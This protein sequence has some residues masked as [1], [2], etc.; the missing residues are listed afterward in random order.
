MIRLVKMQ[1]NTFVLAD[2]AGKIVYLRLLVCGL[3]RENRKHAGTHTMHYQSDPVQVLAQF[4]SSW[5]SPD[6]LAAF[7]SPALQEDHRP[8]ENHRASRQI[9]DATATPRRRKAD[10]P[11]DRN[12]THQQPSSSLQKV[13]DRLLEFQRCY[14]ARMEQF[15]Q[16][17]QADLYADV[18]GT[19]KLNR[20]SR[21]ISA[22]SPR[23]A[24]PVFDRLSAPQ[25]PSEEPSAAEEVD[26]AALRA[27]S[28]AI[29][30][31][32]ADIPHRGIQAQIDWDRSRRAKQENQR[33]EQ[34][35]RERQACS[36]APK[37]NPK[38]VR[39]V[40]HVNVADPIR[41]VL[42]VED[43]LL[44]QHAEV[45]FEKELRRHTAAKL[46]S[47]EE[48]SS[49]R[50]AR[51]AAEA[52]AL[53]LFQDAEDRR[54]A[55]EERRRHVDELSRL[56]DECGNIMSYQRRSRLDGQPDVY[57]KLA[58]PRCRLIDNATVDPE[59]TGTPK[60]GAY[61]ELLASLSRKT[62]ASA[63]DRLS[64]AKTVTPALR[65]VSDT[66]LHFQPQIDKRSA[67]ID[68]VRSGSA[69]GRQRAVL[70][71]QKQA[72][73]DA[74]RQRL[75]REQELQ[76]EARLREVERQRHARHATRAKTPDATYKRMQAWAHRNDNRL[77]AVRSQVQQVSE[78]E[79]T[80]TPSINR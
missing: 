67:E 41:L 25:P 16:K 38:S 29:N 45:E 13:E 57:M 17:K 42:S 19:P 10:P 30:K 12:A 32:S 78:A 6:V 60:I 39:L 77:E 36:S 34:E 75:Q 48:G 61:S 8:S 23:C 5:E 43:R 51:E 59:L 4:R 22:V 58:E 24:L 62:E 49:S 3:K 18:T 71:L 52:A 20:A 1:C 54:R 64:A 53:R 63:F 15:R 21:N 37:L 7:H 46:Q 72:M 2:S 80:F 66:D 65:D 11:V 14:A 27:V 33:R 73:Y 70:L 76:E 28:P 55:V 44:R 31:R 50:R 56:D 47:T 35:E 26:A 9:R 74:H 69:G 40:N 68:K 79:C